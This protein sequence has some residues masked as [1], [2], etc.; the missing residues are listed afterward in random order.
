MCPLGLF[1]LLVLT[2]PKF[3]S[4]VF[5][6]LL[7]L[8]S[9][10]GILFFFCN[11]WMRSLERENVSDFPKTGCSQVQA[12]TQRMPPLQ[13]SLQNQNASLHTCAKCSHTVVMF[14][15][16]S[17]NGSSGRGAPSPYNSWRQPLVYAACWWESGDLFSWLSGCLCLARSLCLLALA[18]VLLGL[19]SAVAIPWN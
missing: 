3:S 1:H 6:F 16:R 15:S 7:L 14:C 2:Q 13:C 19:W 4:W 12:R 8:L 5:F 10:F 18:S 11:V 9:S 17:R